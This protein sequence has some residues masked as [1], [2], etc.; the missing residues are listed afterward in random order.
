MLN[1]GARKKND[2]SRID[3]RSPTLNHVS[4]AVSF[5]RRLVTK[6]D[7]AVDRGDPVRRRVL[8]TLELQDPLSV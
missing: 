6:V 2:T 7:G 3:T 1:H 5:D 8:G 4:I